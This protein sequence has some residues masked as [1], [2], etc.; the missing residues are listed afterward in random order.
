MRNQMSDYESFMNTLRFMELRKFIEITSINNQMMVK[1]TLKG[2]FA[3]KFL[4]SLVLPFVES[5]WV[6]L[7]FLKQ[8]SGSNFLKVGLVEKKI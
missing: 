4:A 3:I 2:K 7:S 1:V 8:I 5:Y 6:T